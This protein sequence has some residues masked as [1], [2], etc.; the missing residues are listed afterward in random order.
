MRLLAVLP[1]ALLASCG[2][3][4]DAGKP[5]ERGNAA[6]AVGEK[7]ASARALLVSLTEPRRQGRYAPRDECGAAPGAEEFRLRLA[8]AVARRDAAALVALSDP[9]IRLDFGG[10]SGTAELRNRLAAPGWELWSALENLLPLGCAVDPQGGIIMPWY[11]LQDFGERDPYSLLV[12][13]GEGVPMLAAPRKNAQVLA[14]LSWEAV[15]LAESTD[16]VSPYA[17]VS[18]YNGVDGYIAWDRLRSLIDYRL[19]AEK[20]EE[21]WKL[22]AFVAGD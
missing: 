9:H 14:R 6:P 16:D 7:Q 20:G 19:I 11:F 4:E 2:E 18:D 3:A 13:R 17:K 5:A 8:D 1:L 21:G 22:T 10:G 12:V 15:E